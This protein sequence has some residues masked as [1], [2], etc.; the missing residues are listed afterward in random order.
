MRAHPTVRSTAE[1][2]KSQ[3]LV[4]CSTPSPNQPLEYCPSTPPPSPLGLCPS[5]PPPGGV[6]DKG[7]Q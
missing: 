4:I 3:V 6:G 5:R 2:C 7:R 1:V